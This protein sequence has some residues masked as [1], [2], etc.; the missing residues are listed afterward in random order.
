MQ[1]IA[2]NIDIP[3]YLNAKS[4]EKILKIYKQSAFPCS[5]KPVCTLWT[6]ANRYIRYNI[7]I[8]N[9]FLVLL[10]ISDERHTQFYF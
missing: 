7:N 4:M 8:T 2:R 5:L 1:G 6:S 10:N 3:F 9:S